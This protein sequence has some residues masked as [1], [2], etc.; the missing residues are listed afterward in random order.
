MQ[1]NAV[2]VD[3]KA[4]IEDIAI[5]EVAGDSIIKVGKRRFIKIVRE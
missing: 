2:E 5:S 4:I 1:Q 3:G